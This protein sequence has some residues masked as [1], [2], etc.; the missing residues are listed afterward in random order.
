MKPIKPD[1]E[2]VLTAREV[3]EYL[4]LDV[5]NT[6]RKYYRELGGVRVGAAYRFFERTL[7]DAILR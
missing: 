3:A 1:L 7:T 2:R 6:N 5:N 4:C